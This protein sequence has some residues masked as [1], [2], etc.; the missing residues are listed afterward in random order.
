[1]MNWTSFKRILPAA[2]LPVFYVMLLSVNASAI[3][4]PRGGGELPEGFKTGK[5][6]DA[7][8]FMPGRGWIGKAAQVRAASL[9]AF[10]T[11]APS[12]TALTGTMRIPVIGGLYTDYVGHTLQSLTLLQVELFD[13]P[14]ATGT[15]AQYFQ[16]ASRGLF[17]V[18][19]DV[20]GWVE[21]AN[22]EDY[23]VVPP[24]GGTMVG[25]S[26]TNEFIEEA[27]AG[28]D[29]E[30]DFG[31][32]DNDGPDGLPNSGDDDGYVDALVLVHP[33][34][35]AECTS[36]FYH[37]WSHSYQYSLWDGVPG[38][39]LATD[40]PA[41]GGGFILIDDYIMAPTVSCDTGLI[42]I[43]VF[44]HELGHTIGLP[45]LYDDYGS[46]GIGYW[47][48]MGSG[49]W[50]T[51]E[52][53]A[54]PCGWSKEQLGWVDVTEVGWVPEQI[55]L[56]PVIQAGEVI[57]LN[58][59]TRRFRRTVPPSSA[60]GWGMVC[61]YNESE[62]DFRGWPGG[63]GYGNDWN[64]SISRTFRFGGS[65]PVTLSYYVQTDLEEYYDFAYVLLRLSTGTDVETLAVYTGQNGFSPETIDLSPYLTGPGSGYGYTV[66]F[67]MVSDFNFSDEDGYFNSATARA[68][69]ID[70]VS[71]QGG[72]E[73]YFTDFEQDT[74]GWRETSAPAEYFLVE[75][76]TKAGFDI[77]LP[78]EGLLI[79]HAE[80]SLAYSDLGNSGG[81]SNTQTRGLV[82][83]EADGRYDLIST[84]GNAGDSGDPYPGSTRN[85]DF[86][87]SSWP[88][89][90][91]NNGDPT[92]V[93]VRGI[94]DGSAFFSAGMPA[95]TVASIEPQEIDKGA[96][97]TV[98]FDIRG[99]G[100]LFGAGC[101][102]SRMDQT[103]EADSVGWLGENR[104]I[105]RFGVG[106]L[107]SGD[108]DVTVES[109]DG[110]QGTL[111]G[112]LTVI[113]TIVSAGVE[114][115]LEYIRPFWSVSPL[116]GLVGSLIYR[117]EAGG[118][119][120]QLGDTLRSATG[121]FEYLDESVSPGA[122]YMYSI[123]VIYGTMHEDLTFSGEYT[124]IEHDFRIVA[125]DVETGLFYLRPIWLVS[126]VE[127]LL[128]SLIYRSDDGGP[129]TQLSDTLRSDTGG[130]EY[131]DES[132]SPGIAY[133]YSAKVIYDYTE[134]EFVFSGVY[135]IGDYDF[136][137][138]GQYPNPFSRSTK[139]IFFSPGPGDVNVRFFDVS[140]KLVDD[141]GT[142][143]YGRGTHEVTWKPSPARIASGVYFCRVSR[144]D[145]S[146][147]LKTVLVR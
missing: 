78:G 33:A 83:Q 70:N 85:T 94:N 135:S 130:F 86:Y 10:S 99:T 119:F 116:D 118:P 68:F 137:V 41:A 34:M 47:G 7:R 46:Y 105:A 125:S 26:R 24:S 21:L 11:G 38:G 15:M 146:S 136:H 62:A 84:G 132:V 140:G 93:S 101:S 39:A 124:T 29:V 129:F 107:F 96:G 5:G 28:V 50:N 131:I 79:W 122:T 100:I 73:D 2:L 92:P 98:Y 42:E 104:I 113:S 66:S 67:N 89:S 110:Q 77:N 88:S 51:P 134:E 27:V 4:S 58:T 53:P 72:G 95:P 35:G 126:P 117:S 43:G 61:G 45:D 18:T 112:G 76:R 103:V 123:S 32:Y 17:D 30:V 87:M 8:S 138:I 63:A 69:L 120:L 31:Q 65:G 1:M 91:D 14:W 59:P 23:Y 108:W 133:R 115:G 40:D 57:R 90:D 54:H 109:G 13:G 82:L 102:L 9:A 3:V 144:G 143:S 106:S 74:G 25:Y 48:L 44:C 19:G 60:T 22:D 114:T 141:L 56:L 36:N 71:V 6:K 52:S 121:G 64:E 80:N 81:S 20:Y 139:I 128:G 127:R 12:E 49:N 97:D 111:D 145:L 142:S 37:M 55:Q 147:T 75:Y 16:E